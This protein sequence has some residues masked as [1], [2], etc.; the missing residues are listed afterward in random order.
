M[1]PL[2]YK[3]RLKL[4]DALIRVSLFIH[5]ELAILRKKIK[6]ESANLALMKEILHES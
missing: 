1:N 6:Q 2:I 3:L 4:A 5:P